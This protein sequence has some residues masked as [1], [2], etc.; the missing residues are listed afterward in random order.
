MMEVGITTDRVNGVEKRHGVMSIE[1]LRKLED[2]SGLDCYRTL[3]KR[4]MEVQRPI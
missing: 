4:V 1:L 3:L 2:S